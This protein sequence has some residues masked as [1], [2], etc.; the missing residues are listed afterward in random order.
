[1]TMTNK[2]ITKKMIQEIKTRDITNLW[3]GIKAGLN[4]FDSD[5]ATGNIP[6]LMVLTD[7]LPNHR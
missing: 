3:G 1:M 2:N 7:G 4:L 5:G 6:A